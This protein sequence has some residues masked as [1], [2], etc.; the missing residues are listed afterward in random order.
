MIKEKN[1]YSTGGILM[2]GALVA[3]TMISGVILAS[4]KTTAAEDTANATVRVSSACT[5]SSTVSS[6]HTASVLNGTYQAGIGTTTLT[7]NCNDT[8]GY[9][10]YAVGFSG[11][12]LGNTNMIGTTTAETIATGTATTGN[13][14]AWAMKIASVGTTGPAVETG[15]ANYAAVPATYTKIASQPGAT[16]TTS[17]SAITTTY[18]VYISGSQ[19]ADTY[20]GQVKYSLV[21]P[22]TAA[23]P[24]E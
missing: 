4:E 6:E 8:N 1:I 23:T 24:T 15:F 12:T 18:S 13:N 21:H 19:P 14:S 20:V 11:D 3:A 9:A 7:A 17:G 16:D 5:L 10:V 2:L 22:S